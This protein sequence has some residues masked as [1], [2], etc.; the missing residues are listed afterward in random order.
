MSQ[1]VV[2]KVFLKNQLISVKQFTQAQIVIGKQSDASLVLRHKDVAQVHAVIEE[3]NGKYFLCDLGS[4]TGTEVHGQRI[5][6]HEL[7]DGEVFSISDLKIH[8]FIG[9]PGSK[10]KAENTQKP[11]VQKTSEPEA[12]VADDDA[13]TEDLSAQALESSNESKEDQVEAKEEEVVANPTPEKKKEIPISPTSIQNL[14]TSLTDKEVQAVSDAKQ[15]KAEKSKTVAK[16][17][18]PIIH[19]QKPTGQQKP[20]NSTATKASGFMM[21]GAAGQINTGSLA[22]NVNT[23]LGTFAP[24]ALHTDL[25]E[26]ID[27]N[28][29][30]SVVEVLVTWKERIIST[31]HFSQKQQVTLGNKPECDIQVPVLDFKHTFININNGAQIRL[32][33]RMDGFLYRG[34]QQIPFSALRDAGQLSRDGDCYLLNLAQGE[35]ARCFL[36][37]DRVQAYICY[38]EQTPKAVAVPMFDFTASEIVAVAM[39]FILS[40]L[41]AVYMT[42]YT[43]KKLGDIETLMEDQYRIAV[44]EFKPPPKMVIPEDIKVPEKPP[45]EIKKPEKVVTKVSDKKVEKAVQKPVKSNQKVGE[46]QSLGKKGKPNTVADNKKGTPKDLAPN[47]VKVKKPGMASNKPGGSVATAK[48]DDANAQTKKKDVTKSGLLNVLSSGGAASNLDKAYSGAGSTFGLADNATGS[49]GS[50]SNRPGEGL[51]TDLKNVSQG[52]KGTSTV[53]IAG[54]NSKGRAGGQTGYGGNDGL[55]DKGRMSIIN[56]EGNS[57][58]FVSTIDKEAI[59]RII[60]RNKNAIKSCYDVELTRNPNI[61]GKIVLEWEIVDGGRMVNPKVKSSDVASKSLG[62]CIISRLRVLKFPDPGP[63]E[64]AQVAFPFVFEAR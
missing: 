47:D 61:A 55:G 63:N 32:P 45:E 26:V 17:S 56:V 31:T 33:G 29:R 18:Q 11:V 16:T 24:Q 54:I 43:P 58:E 53:G 60:Q 6:E 52:G 39:S 42:F 19:S 50:A 14:E 30:G 62:N 57:G 48:S 2:I 51:G 10:G 64:I 20:V 21:G 12:L 36:M 41:I 35:M 3:R 38:V 22:D 8:F 59:K 5:L 27:V 34:T 23:S 49:G 44:I 4:E 13:E 46:K 9:I 37:G 25:D 28:S 1:I 40:A 7:R 15:E